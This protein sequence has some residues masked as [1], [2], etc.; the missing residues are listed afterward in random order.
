MLAPQ[1]TARHADR[2]YA[3]PSMT[4]GLSSRAQ[5]VASALAGA[6]APVTEQSPETPDSVAFT[7]RLDGF[8]ARLPW[9]ERYG[10]RAFFAL[11]NM[12]PILT[13]FGAR[14]F[15]GMTGPDQA[16][17]MARCAESR[18]LPLRVLAKFS[19][20]L[21]MPAFYA[22]PGIR[23]R[24]GD[25]TQGLIPATSRTFPVEV[26]EQVVAGGEEVLEVDVVIVGSGAGGAPLAKELAERGLRVVVL[27]AGGYRP[28]HTFPALAFDALSE[29]YRDAG[30]T[31]TVG[32][33]PV[34]VPVGKLVGG[35]TVINSG[36]C[37]RI[38][39]FVHAK[40]VANY[41]MPDAI[42]A[43]SLAPIYERVEE[44]ISVR[45]VPQEILG[46]NNDIARIGATAKGWSHGYLPRNE[47][48]CAGSNRCAFG[49]P[50]D[51]KQAM[52]L[53]YLPAAVE[54]GARVISGAKVTKITWDGDRATGVVAKVNGGKT[55]RV[56]AFSTVVAAG[57]FY[58]PMLLRK[59]GVRHRNLGRRLT[60]HP[61]LKASALFPGQDFYA[62]PAVPQS[63]YVDEFQQRGVMM[64]G[65]H[66]PPDMGCVALPGK[67][68]EH[69]A[70]MERSREISTF[71]FLVS[72]EPA[73]RVHRGIDGRPFVR[74][75]ITPGD[76]QKMLFGLKRLCELFA[77]AGAEEVYLP[78]WKLPILPGDADFEA[79]IDKADIK[80]ADLELAA[81]HPLGTCGF[82]PDAETFPL[83]TDLKVRGRE[84]LFVADGSIFP[85]SLAVNPQLS[86]M[87]MATRLAWH[88]DETVL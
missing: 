58:T 9:P 33:P 80:P 84:G 6:L 11:V 3:R 79:E 17:F 47:K 28:A 29:L 78:T 86:I 12:A 54:A 85:S 20:F 75:D 23:E 38:P 52:H 50:T 76:H 46:A 88:L 57:T 4:S 18:L 40:W 87:A 60:L 70:L 69:Q 24:I 1:V 7:P 44:L 25:R 31:V 51:G 22:D 43:E 59:N 39:E 35:T 15:L 62:L 72:D 14:T 61:A 77:A 68:P 30:V 73:G 82:G 32:A 64:E 83:D 65:A 27:E 42:S 10:V 81:F 45:P 63:Y 19:L 13:F 36:T 8:I 16:R 21:C 55:L 34:I 66:L 49:C 56:K 74:Y 71:G 37:F 67:G 2:R 26:G 48:G 5:R 53:T 41:G